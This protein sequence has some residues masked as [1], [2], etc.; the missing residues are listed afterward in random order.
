MMMSRLYIIIGMNSSLQS[1]VNNMHKNHSEKLA[2]QDDFCSKGLA[3]LA[4]RPFE[5]I[6]I[7]VRQPLVQLDL[8]AFGI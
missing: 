4:A 3:A 5:Q 6:K 8:A 1:N 7:L 2:S